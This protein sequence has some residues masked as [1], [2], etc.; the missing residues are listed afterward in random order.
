MIYKCF[1]SAHRF[2]AMRPAK[3]WKDAQALLSNVRIRILFKDHWGRKGPQ[4]LNLC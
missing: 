3:F 2:I 1:S 4:D